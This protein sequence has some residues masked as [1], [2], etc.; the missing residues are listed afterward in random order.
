MRIQSLVIFLAL[1]SLS[2]SIKLECIDITSNMFKILK[3][4]PPSNGPVTR[5]YNLKLITKKLAPD[6]YT[7]LVRTVN[8][9]YP[10]PIIQANYG[11]RL[12]I[13]VINELG[14]FS[15]LHWHGIFQTGTNFYDGVPGVTQCPI[16]NHGNFTYNFTVNQYGTFW[17]HSHFSGQLVDGLK[18]PLIIHNHKDPYLKTY[19]FEYVV[20][21]SEWYH[22]QANDI[23]SILLSPS[24][25]GGDPIPSSGEISGKGQYNCAFASKNSLCNPNNGVAKY[26]V[27]KGK[28]YR[29]RIINMSGST[30]YIF[31]I[32]EHPLTLIEV[33]GH[34]I[35]EVTIK[36]IPINTAQRY[37]VI[38]NANKPV[39]NYYIR[40][41]LT[42]CT[43]FN[44]QTLNYNYTLNPNVVGILKYDGAKDKT[45]DSKAYPL[46]KSEECRDL[47]PNILKP[48]KLKPPKHATHKI[49]LVISFKKLSTTGSLAFINNLS[50]VA[51]F[52]YPTNQKII[53]KLNVNKFQNAYAYDCYTK[54]CKN[55]AVDI[56]IRIN[57]THSHPFHLHGHSFFVMYNGENQTGIEPPDPSDF[58]LIDPV[59]RDIVT[60]LGNSTTVIRYPIDNPGV[61]F[62]HCHMHWHSVKGMATQLI[63]RK[64]I[65][66]NMSVP[67]NLFAN[68]AS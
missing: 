59:Y 13:N 12:L 39:K 29:F 62:M 34:L 15:T 45:P 21:L 26:I 40:A 37:S 41:K 60:V 52:N 51:D 5:C 35:K 55:E 18:G 22:L 24:Y 57:H 28:K 3:L 65:I 66:T 4:L 64:S 38:L 20:T 53:N 32:D 54:D 11:D 17:Y 16:P 25:R 1:F 49:D 67:E 9:Q 48:Y 36:T 2:D 33:D 23:E 68:C 10:A 56:Y 46:N 50:F 43:P 44:N 42:V 61:W 14:E 58:N 7:R 6:G 30:H 19:D 27:K 47:N 8:G 63:E 31:S